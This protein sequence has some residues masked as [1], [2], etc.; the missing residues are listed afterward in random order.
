MTPVE[1][2]TMFSRAFTATVSACVAGAA[3]AGASAGGASHLTR[4]QQWITGFARGLGSRTV[5]VI[6]ETDSLALQS[7]LS[8]SQITAR[9]QAISQAVQTIKAANPDARVYLDGGHSA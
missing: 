5:I 3:C 4:Y 9:D 2:N 8:G 1:R 7:C 6:L